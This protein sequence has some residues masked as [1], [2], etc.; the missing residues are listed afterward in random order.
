MSTAKD[1]MRGRGGA[2]RPLAVRAALSGNERGHGCRRVGGRGERLRWR[3]GW[4]AEMTDGLGRG[5]GRAGRI[6]RAC[7]AETVP[8]VFFLWS[9][10]S[11]A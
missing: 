4:R 11:L 3:T 7:R 1:E 5:W 10:V 8:L 9:Q 2:P 6:S